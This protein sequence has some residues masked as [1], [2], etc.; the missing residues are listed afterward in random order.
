MKKIGEKLIHLIL[1]HS[2]LVIVLNI[3]LTLVAALSLPKIKLENSIDVFFNK[4]SKSYVDFEKWKEQFGS[5]EIVIVAFSDKDIFTED[6]LRL[7]DNLTGQFE[8]LNY[9]NKVTSLTNVNN[10][11][12]AES[13]FFVQPLVVNIPSTKKELARLKEEAVHNPL[14]VDNVISRDGKTTAI[15]IELEKHSGTGGDYKKETVESIYK[16]LKNAFPENKKFYLSGNTAIEYFYARYM[17]DDLKTFMPLLFLILLV[18]LGL[19]S[20]SIAGVMLPLVVASIS[21]IWTMGFL[22]LCGFS[23]NNVT[24][25]IPPIILS[26]ALLDSIHFYWELILKR[27]TAQSA[28]RDNI[29]ILSDT[30]REL[31]IPCFLTSATTLVGFLSLTVSRIPPVKELGLVVGIGIFFALF[32][33]F[34]FLPV[35]TKKLNLLENLNA[36][37]EKGR[38]FFKKRLDHFFIGIGNF[39]ERYRIFVLVATLG[40][41]AISVWGIT[42]LKVE[43]NVLDYFKKNSPIHKSTTFIENNLS[44]IHFLNISLKT[45]IR[46]YFKRPKSLREIEKLEKFLKTLPSVDKTTSVV[47]YIKEINKSFHNE[48]GK[49]YKVPSSKELISQYLLLYGAEDLD[50]FVD[51]QWQ[52]TTIQV[53]L[54]E[55]STV[56]L[57]KIITRIKEYL[58]R[59]ISEPVKTKVLGQTVLEVETN[60][61]VMK[62]QLQSLGLAMLVIFSMIFLLF[63]SIPVGLV[64]I[65]PNLLPIV[66]NFG[67]MGWLGIRLDSATSMI[68]AIGIGIIVDDTIHFLHSFRESFRKTGDYTLSMQRSLAQKGR[69]IVL[70][71]VILFFGFGIV[72]VSQFV[73]SAYFGLLSA[74]LIFNAL[75]ADLIVLPCILLCMKPRF[76]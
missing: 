33:T 25:I 36:Q 47:E 4:K 67:I 51:S 45:D 57:K 14:Y 59:T 12:G 35:L 31:F 19:S 73:P 23:I 1:K 5:D 34:T 42:R 39:N 7:I 10:I 6:N 70:T 22:Y 13:T 37:E 2:L 74:L 8:S 76:R 69:P 18:I 15:L 56:R 30:I 63:R 52:W 24:T 3:F 48:N 46:D 17:Q 62:G 71:S 53:R 32:V 54:K 50:D 43:T 28:S 21:L 66:V 60:N 44:G 49:F 72:S 68:S 27:K 38:G 20:R 26:V 9:V 65:V 29:F 55:H 11:I 41:I 64:S 75:W 58:T 40:L 16:I 61:A